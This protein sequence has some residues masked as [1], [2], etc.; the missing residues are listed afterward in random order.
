MTADQLSG[1]LMQFKGILK[2]EWD[3]CIDDDL[4][5]TEGNYEKVIG[6]LQERH[7]S[8]CVGLVRE[9]YGQKKND[10]LRWANRW[11]QGRKPIS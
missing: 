10:L 1:K 5:Q 4:Q 7:G 2:Q 8:A 6:M 3:K 11:L 9:Q